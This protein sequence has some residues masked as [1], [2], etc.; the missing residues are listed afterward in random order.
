MRVKHLLLHYW[1]PTY[2][3]VFPSSIHQ[4]CGIYRLLCQDSWVLL[5]K[6][7]KASRDY[8]TYM[9]D[10]ATC[11][12]F[13]K[14]DF[15]QKAIVELAKGREVAVKYGDK[16]FGKRPDVLSYPADVFDFAKDGVTSFHI[17]EE[18]WENP[19][20]LK[21]G[22]TKKEAD[23]LRDGWDF[24]IDI[25]SKDWQISK[26]ATWLI[27]CTLKDFGIKNISVK[28]SGNKGFHIGLPYES[29][30]KTIAGT[31][32]ASSFPELPKKLAGFI[33]DYI[34]R[35]YLT[36]TSDSVKFGDSLSFGIPELKSMMKEEKTELLKS[37]CQNCGSPIRKDVK[38]TV[39]FICSHC[40]NRQPG[41]GEFMRCSRCGKLTER[42]VHKDKLCNCG[43]TNIVK[44][45][46]ILSVIEIDTLLISSRHMYRSVYSLHEK[47][48]LASVPIDPEKVMEFDKATAE[49]DRITQPGPGFLSKGPEGEAAGLFETALDYKRDYSTITEEDIGDL[50]KK[51]LD[52]KEMEN[53][54]PAE[55]F[56]PCIKK[57]LGGL[58]DG[59]KRAMF[60]LSNFLFNVGWEYDGCEELMKEWNKS[61]EDPLRETVLLGHLKYHKQRKEK[62]LPPNCSNKAYYIDMGICTPDKLCEKIKNPVNYTRRKVFMQDSDE[63]KKKKKKAGKPKPEKD[64][65]DR[66]KKIDL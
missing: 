21:P 28:F 33:V 7:L 36:V 34:E 31:D 62:V 52:Y 49:P 60:I 59:K 45:L 15:V 20:L 53:A 56:P 13:Y 32:T 61:N 40:G 5:E 11:L 18:R 55:L 46:N 30:P 16:G 24:I 65:A 41:E 66:E 35:N 50:Q 26:A 43:K 14:K 63:G 4:R 58:T 9:V 48:G 64:D 42:I 38:E 44:R 39:E 47:S 23:S 10:F 37:I 1:A 8:C 19:L 3:A 29:F 57:I 12:R 54:A 6:V 27:V 25:D 51:N 2:P 17:S 22:M